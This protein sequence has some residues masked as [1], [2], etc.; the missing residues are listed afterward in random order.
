MKKCY[1]LS[2]EDDTG[3]KWVRIVIKIIEIMKITI[4]QNVLE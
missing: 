1:W 3:L 2:A 4:I